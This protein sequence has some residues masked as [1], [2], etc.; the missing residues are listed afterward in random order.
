MAKKFSIEAIFAA[1]D[2]LSAPIGKIIG[3][4]GQLGRAG[5]KGLASL[6]GAVNKS[7]KALGKFSSEIGVASVVSLG[8]LAY[9]M[10][11]VITV[12]REFE[13]T[14]IRT[15]S[16][17]EVPARQ[18]TAA[19]AAL[20]AAAMNVGDTTEFTSQQG[21][22]GLN[23][24]ATAGYTVEQSIA[25]LPKII[26][27]A[28]AAT[29]ELGQ[30][31]DIT[32][33]TLG[34]F[35][36]R[37]TDA[38]E[39]TAQMAR[40]M[41]VM[42]RAAADSTTNVA[43]LFEGIR[44][45]G[46]FAKTT[47]ATLEQFAAL[48]G[49]LANKGTKGA[50]AG[51]AIRNAYLHLTTQTKQAHDAQAKLGVVTA[52]NKDGSIDMITTIG[53]FAKA[54][55]KLTKDQKGAAIATI[56]GAFAVGPFLSLMDAGEK[57][58]RAFADRL[59]GAGGTAH[60]MALAMRESADAKI[61]MFWNKLENLR[62]TVFRAIAPTVLEIADAV[63]K[64]VTANKD[65]VSAK[66]AEWATTLKDVLPVIAA[67]LPRIAKGFAAF[68]VFAGTVKTA[69]LAIQGY[70]AATKIVQGVQ[71][72]WNT[73]VTA[74]TAALNWSWVAT[75]RMK[76]AQIA[77]RVATFV[78][79][80]VQTAYAAVLNTTAIASGRVRLAEIASKVA[81]VASRVA[82][83]VATGVQTAYAAVLAVTSGGLAA[84]RLAA[85]ASVPAITAQVVAMAPML[86]MVGAVMAAVLALV[87]AWDQYNKLDKSLAGSGGVT[88][89]VGKMIE[90]GTW[91]PF[92]AH[93]AVM[94][95]KAVAARREQD[96]KDAA[97]PQ[98]QRPQIVPPQDRAAAATAAATAGE[99]AS[100]DGTITVEAKPGTKASVKARPSPVGL[101]LQPSGAL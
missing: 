50:E 38:A 100:V 101:K 21:A 34:A 45:G 91:D 22:E 83:V 27:F 30:A 43:E 76:V 79:T 67:W 87:A 33:D 49:T 25:A 20:E 14:L 8:A 96:K 77:S 23:S 19:F 40:V 6:D 5:K 2:R 24:L 63:G 84:F 54:T 51:T 99:N 10:S 47:G 64:W 59:K 18:G 94:N 17:F 15:G 13:K 9:E 31:S 3:K 93:D 28:S 32:S 35:G 82:T 56:F 37:T 69:T 98:D 1:K 81:Q 65:L 61:A 95:E 70:E 88:G 71:W 53:R 26:D 41:D 44:A 29:L 85:F 78:A 62:L 92:A 55:Q 36:L 58:V 42:T 57:D 12:G 89:T 11:N 66:A 75:V 72:A 39:N 97:P 80:G 74:T 46:A 86:A 73:A 68:V 60:E 4:L 90:M 52:K 7:F 16:A 48:Q